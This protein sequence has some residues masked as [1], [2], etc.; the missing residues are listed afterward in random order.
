M[1]QIC[2]QKTAYDLKA[3]R[4]THSLV[5][6]LLLLRSR[7]S[8]MV[9]YPRRHQHVVGTTIR[10]RGEDVMF[11]RITSAQPPTSQVQ[12]QSSGT[13]VGVTTTEL[14]VS[15]RQQH[16]KPRMRNGRRRRRG[17][18]GISYSSG[19]LNLGKTLFPKLSNYFQRPYDCYIKVKYN[20][21][22][23]KSISVGL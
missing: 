23:F 20:L 4:P 7:Q 21:M 10:E 16:V 8:P 2:R 5:S 15:Q 6:L 22:Y 18:K 9:Y 11:S 12:T 13:K 14:Q 3:K 1:Q 19:H 17:R